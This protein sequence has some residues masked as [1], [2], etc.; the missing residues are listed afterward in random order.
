[1]SKATKSKSKQ[2]RHDPLYDQIRAD[3]IETK[4]IKKR[5]VDKKDAK[6]VEVCIIYFKIG[7]V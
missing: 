7:L 2:Q 6:K 1:M 4:G 5:V 3:Q